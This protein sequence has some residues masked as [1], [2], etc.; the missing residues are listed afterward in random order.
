MVNGPIGKGPNARGQNGKGRNGRG[1][2]GMILS[3]A[4]LITDLPPKH[5]YFIFYSKH[6]VQSLTCKC[7]QGGSAPQT[8]IEPWE[9]S[10]PLSTNCQHLFDK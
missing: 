7:T 9:L 2:S 3:N 5:P 6:Y 1:Q 10:I 8:K 4:Q